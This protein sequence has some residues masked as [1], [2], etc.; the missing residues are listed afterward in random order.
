MAGCTFSDVLV[1]EVKDVKITRLQGGKLGMKV[2]IQIYNPNSIKFEVSDV[3][4]NIIL[5]SIE[6]GKITEYGEVEIHKKSREVYAFPVDLQLSGLL[7]GAMVLLSIA[8]KDD[9]DFIIDGQFEVKY[10]LGKKSIP[11]HSEGKVAID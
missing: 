9:V 2:Y 7:K 5:N 11:V 6:V 10:F 8:G 4:I 1:E 3:D